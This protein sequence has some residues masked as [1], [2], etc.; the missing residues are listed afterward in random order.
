MG[1]KDEAIKRDVFE[2]MQKG[3]PFATYKKTTLGAIL[4]KTLD[5]IRLIPEEVI[6]KGDPEKNEDGCFLTVWTAAEDKYIR[7]NNKAHFESGALVPHSAVDEE[8]FKINSISDEEIE[9]ILNQPFFALQS[10]LKA[11]TSSIPVRRF[12]IAAEKMNKPVKTIEY[13]KS[14]LSEFEREEAPAETP[15]RVDVEY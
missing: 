5:P 12:L 15:S 7:K 1:L 13:I 2:V 6:L 8:Y 14:V 11:F 9:L 3:E 10:K 4:V